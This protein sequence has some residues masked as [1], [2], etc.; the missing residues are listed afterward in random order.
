LGAQSHFIICEN[1]FTLGHIDELKMC[2]QNE[3]VTCVL[4]E[5]SRGATSM[6]AHYRYWYTFIDVFC[7]GTESNVNRSI[8]RQVSGTL[9]S[10]IELAAR[11][12]ED[13][14][15]RW[16]EIYPRVYPNGKDFKHYL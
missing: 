5:G 14:Y 4:Q 3:F 9:D 6:Q 11:G 1:S 13:F 8:C 10:C 15:R 7:Y 12:T 2:V 16:N